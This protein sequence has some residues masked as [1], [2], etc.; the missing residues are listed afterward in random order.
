MS[1]PTKNPTLLDRV[2]SLETVNKTQASLLESMV[3]QLNHLRDVMQGIIEVVGLENVN[4]ALRDINDRKLQAEEDQIQA[5]IK[6]LEEMDDVKELDSVEPQST[7]AVTETQDG[8]VV[9]TSVMFLTKESLDA[10]L[11]RDLTGAKPGDK[12]ELGQSVI[13]IKRIFKKA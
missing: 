13:E 12:F 2:R 4:Q 3:E 7:V 6:R 5:T 8:V 10:N 1:K 9:G 11:K